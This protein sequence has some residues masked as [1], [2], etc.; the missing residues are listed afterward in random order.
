MILAWLGRFNLFLFILFIWSCNLAYY[1]C[2]EWA[3]V[4]TMG[5]F[6]HVYLLKI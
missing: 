4:Q 5:F 3:K 6:V 2:A 1:T